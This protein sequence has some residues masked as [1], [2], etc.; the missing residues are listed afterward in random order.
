MDLGIGQNLPPVVFIDGVNEMGFG[1]AALYF[2]GYASYGT[3]DLQDQKSPLIAA[4]ELVH[5]LLGLSASVE[6][7]ATLLRNITIIGTEDPV[8]QSIA[9]LHWIMADQSGVC[10]VTVKEYFF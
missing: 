10:M 8:T 5:F 1:A 4:V 2:P 7:A 6:Q 3:A 9:P